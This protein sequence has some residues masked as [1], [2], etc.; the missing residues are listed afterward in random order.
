[1]EHW[2]GRI[3]DVHEKDKWHCPHSVERNV[4][5]LTI[6]QNLL[7]R[8]STHN[9][10]EAFYDQHDNRWGKSHHFSYPTDESKEYYRMIFHRDKC[11]TD[12]EKE[13]E[14]KEFKYIMEH[15]E[16]LYK[17]DMDYLFRILKKH[18]RSW[19]T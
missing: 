10:G 7:K 5:N 3:R 14:H 19:W 4:R 17:Q 9:Y 12:K 13:L 1:M 8:M 11:S 6:C 16:Y 15:E 2:V 18:L